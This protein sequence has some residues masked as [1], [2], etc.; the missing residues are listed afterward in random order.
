MEAGCYI[1]ILMLVLLQGTLAVKYQH[2][3]LSVF[4]AQDSS[5]DKQFDLEDDGDEVLYMDFNLKKEVARI[6]EFNN[7]VMQ[8]GEAGISANIAIMKQN[9][10]VWKN[11][12]RGSPEPKCK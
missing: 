6:P 3:Q 12:S 4:M 10:N 2:E 9:L 1:T 5:P 11:L 8:G 7:H